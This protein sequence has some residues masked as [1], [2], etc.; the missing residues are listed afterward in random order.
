MHYEPGSR[1]WKTSR[2]CCL[3]QHL[4]ASLAVQQALSRCMTMQC[5]KS[6][7]LAYPEHPLCKAEYALNCKKLYCWEVRIST[8]LTAVS[9]QLQLVGLSVLDTARKLKMHCR[10][11]SLY[12]NFVKDFLPDSGRTAQAQRCS[13]TRFAIEC[14]VLAAKQQFEQLLTKAEQ[15][16]L[17]PAGARCLFVC[18][19]SPSTA[20]LSAGAKGR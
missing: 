3:E 4:K 8:N 19:G 18:M 9:M 11:D 2:R 5:M 6:A 1:S 15:V 13:R 20:T 14:D 12:D 7:P 17:L 16:W 10:N